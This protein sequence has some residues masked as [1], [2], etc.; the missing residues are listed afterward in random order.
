ML[1][2][3]ISNLVNGA[4]VDPTAAELQLFGNMKSMQFLVALV[5]FDKVPAGFEAIEYWPDSFLA[6]PGVILRRDVGYAETSDQHVVGGLQTYSYSPE[7]HCD[8]QQH[9]SAMEA[10]MARVGVKP[11]A[12]L[13]R[14]YDDYYPHYNTTQ[15]RMCRWFMPRT[16]AS[17]HR[18]IPAE[19]LGNFSVPGARR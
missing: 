6:S 12:T 5:E 11:V 1:S 18:A 17:R 16:H 3:S 7:P 8:R 15:V 10:W 14:W 19:V 2:G 9:W 4:V 13:Q